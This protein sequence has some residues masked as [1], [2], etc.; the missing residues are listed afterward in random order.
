MGVEGLEDPVRLPFPLLVFSRCPTSSSLP[1][2]THLTHRFAQQHEGNEELDRDDG[3]EGDESEI[4][5][6]ETMARDMEQLKY[7]DPEFYAFLKQDEPSLL[8]FKPTD[9]LMGGGHSDECGD[10]EEDGGEVRDAGEVMS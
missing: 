10:E 9:D 6:E 1:R 8:D 4:E 3:S 5:D 2:V 7:T